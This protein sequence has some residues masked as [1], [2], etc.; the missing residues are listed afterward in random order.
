MINLCLLTELLPQ[1]IKMSKKY[2]RRMKMQRS[3]NRVKMLKKPF[4]N[5]LV[6]SRAP[7]I[8]KVLALSLW[9]SKNVA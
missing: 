5:L 2:H 3:H 4:N 9:N 8:P 7:T 1:Y 6:D